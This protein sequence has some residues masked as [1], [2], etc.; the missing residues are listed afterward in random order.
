[1]VGGTPLSLT[2]PH[3]RPVSRIFEPSALTLATI[4]RNPRRRDTVARAGGALLSTFGSDVAYEERRL[5]RDRGFR[6]AV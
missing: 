4:A 1:M 6:R 2:T 5:A 3:P